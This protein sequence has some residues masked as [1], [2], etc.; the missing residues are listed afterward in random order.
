MKIY[1]VENDDKETVACC[2]TKDLAVSRI[3]ETLLNRF[4]RP[5]LE[6]E[7]REQGAVQEDQEFNPDDFDGWE[8][9]FEYE[10]T[11]AEMELDV[12]VETL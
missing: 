5:Y 3:R 12:P 4:G 8:E 9:F 7:L 6:D 11:I 1:L 10:Y 2:S